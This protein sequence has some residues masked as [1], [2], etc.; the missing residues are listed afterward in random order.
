MANRGMD[1][2]RQAKRD[3]EKA[4]T[5]FDH[6]YYEWACFTAQQAAEKA[7]KALYLLM[8]SYVR[9]HSAV[10]MLEGLKE[11]LDVPEDLLHLA[12]ILDRYYIQSRYPNSFPE[13]A[14]QDYFDRQ[15]AEE[16]YNASGK[17]IGFCE[18]LVRGL[19]GGDGIFKGNSPG[20]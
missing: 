20:T 17:I 4:R 19:Q 2:L 5:D 10:K 18:D 3:L 9:G 11:R 1:W 6:S 8:N 15:I 14:P 13:G 16:A 7:L 12:R